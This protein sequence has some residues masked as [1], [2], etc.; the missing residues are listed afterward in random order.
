M[1]LNAVTVPMP[2]TLYAGIVP[3]KAVS[4]GESMGSNLP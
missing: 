1:C 4:Q 3:T 2:K